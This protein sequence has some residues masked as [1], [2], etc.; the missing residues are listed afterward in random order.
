MEL[1]KKNRGRPGR[2]VWEVDTGTALYHLEL[3]PAEAVELY[4]L[5]GEALGLAQKGN[6]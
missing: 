3:T 5:L 4:K 2:N 1:K 6:T